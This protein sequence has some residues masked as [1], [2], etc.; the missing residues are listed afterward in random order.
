VRCAHATR[1]RPAA[2]APPRLRAG[3]FAGRPGVSVVAGWLAGQRSRWRASP[4]ATPL[5]VDQGVVGRASP[6][7][8]ITMSSR[9]W[10][11]ATRSR[12]FGFSGIGS[13]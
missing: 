7:P 3:T 10:K 11:N 13:G 5:G 4:S 9:S 6:S 8:S 2:P 12:I 1:Y